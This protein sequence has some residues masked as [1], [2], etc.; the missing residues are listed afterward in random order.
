[1]N[2]LL[3]YDRAIKKFGCVYENTFTDSDGTRYIQY[4]HS[5]LI[6]IIMRIDINEDIMG[7]VCKYPN[8]DRIRILED[9]RNF[10][11]IEFRNS[12]I[13]SIL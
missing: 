1:M 12:T 2:R 6:R 3:I 5:D 4:I 7:I 13:D 9:L 11:K 10:I 8:E